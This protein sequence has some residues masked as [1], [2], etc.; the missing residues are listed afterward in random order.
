MTAVM[1]EPGGDSTCAGAPPE[2]RIPYL[3]TSCGW[4]SP[5]T[6]SLSTMTRETSSRSGRRNIVS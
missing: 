6:E 4:E 1:D 3:S 2:W 5:D